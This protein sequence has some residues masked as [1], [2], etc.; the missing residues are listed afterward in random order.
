MYTKSREHIL[1]IL[2]NNTSIVYISGDIHM[3]EVLSERCT[4]HTHGYEMMELTTSGMTHS[5]DQTLNPISHLLLLYTHIYLIKSSRYVYFGNNYLVLYC[6][7]YHRGLKVCVY[8]MNMN[9]YDMMNVYISHRYI[10]HL[11]I[12]ML[13]LIHFLLCIIIYRLSIHIL[14][15]IL[16][17]SD[18]TYKLF[19][20]FR[21]LHTLLLRLLIILE[22]R[23]VVGEL[24]R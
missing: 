10:H 13:M 22:Q 3:A 4:V 11:Y 12:L 21:M 2:N 17:E 6:I 24:R 5:F 15:F 9:I 16:L 8:D 1:S 23:T 19:I 18:S 14:L 7:S 20:V